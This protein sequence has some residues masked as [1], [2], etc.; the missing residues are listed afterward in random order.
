MPMNR[1]SFKEKL[2]LAMNSF[3]LSESLHS[4]TS[5]VELLIPSS[6]GNEIDPLFEFA[7]EHGKLNSSVKTRNGISAP[8]LYGTERAESKKKLQGFFGNKNLAVVQDRQVIK[9]ERFYGIGS[10]PTFNLSNS[11]K[12]VEYQHEDI[13]LV[14]MMESPLHLLY[15]VAFCIQNSTPENI[16]F[17]TDVQRYYA[18]SANEPA[19]LKQLQQISNQYLSNNGLLD[20]EIDSSVK[21]RTITSFLHGRE[22]MFDEILGQVMISLGETFEKFQSSDTFEIMCKNLGNNAHYSLKQVHQVST[23]LKEA[24][25]SWDEK[26]R[27]VASKAN[28]LV[29]TEI[30]K[31][32]S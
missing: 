5:S 20:L 23:L 14:H 13:S 2:H 12:I 24:Q 22:N 3:K 6:A 29:E 31:L 27:L 18:S 21:S 17:V 9:L 8:V 10:I 28:A 16:L 30:A 7:M 1:E 32:H 4:A 26:S 11:T 15:L 19:Q 25:T